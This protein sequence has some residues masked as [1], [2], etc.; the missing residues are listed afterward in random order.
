[1]KYVAAFLSFG[2]SALLAFW[3]V[4]NVFAVIATKGLSSVPHELVGVWPHN[5]IFGIIA[6]LSLG[7][8][9]GGIAVLA[10][11]ERKS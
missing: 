9:A 8:F 5:L 11:R 2:L 7:L 1:M 4:L 6:I 3:L 10:N